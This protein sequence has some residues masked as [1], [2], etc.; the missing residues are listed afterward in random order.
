MRRPQI[1][2]RKMSVENRNKDCQGYE[3]IGF[4]TSAEEGLNSEDEL[5]VSHL[6][7]LGILV[8]PVIWDQ[9]EN[10]N[11]E[12]FDGLIF[13]SCWNYHQKHSEFLDW[14]HQLKALSV[15]IFNP[16]SIIEWNI[17]KKYLLDWNSAPK[18]KRYLKG[19]RFTKNDF[20]EVLSNW[21]LEAVVIKPCVSL[22]GQDTFLVTANDFDQKKL[23][24]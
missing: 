18:T 10:Q 11:L 20:E 8:A 5:S 22:N 21:K 13:R 6:E 4:I 12:L 2:K 17:D 16:L 15:P 1:S 3:K 9:P 23:I 19:Y 7:T 14:I 24:Y